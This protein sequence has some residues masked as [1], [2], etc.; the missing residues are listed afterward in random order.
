MQ[1]NKKLPINR[2]PLFWD[3]SLFKLFSEIGKDYCESWIGQKVILYQV[4]R[5]KTNSDSLY[6]ESKGIED[7]KYRTPI[8]LPCRYDIKESTN[9]AYIKSNQNARY[10]QAGNIEIY[11]YD[12]TLKEYEC[13]I[14]YGDLIGVVIDE[15]TMFYYEIMDDGKRNFSNTETMFGYKRFWRT[16]KGVEIDENV[17]N[18]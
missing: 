14:K 9:E 7:V 18:G 17:F 8:E 13:N 11:I 4:D 5:I 6:G 1:N 3:S 16:I 12:E 10:K 2:N 15:K